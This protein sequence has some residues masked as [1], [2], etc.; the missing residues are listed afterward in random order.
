MISNHCKNK[1]PESKNLNQHP[2]DVNVT[3]S[4]VFAIFNADI[5]AFRS[6]AISCHAINTGRLTEQI[7]LMGTSPINVPKYNLHIIHFIQVIMNKT[8]LLFQ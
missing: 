4:M 2:L 6:T 5:R 8:L 1:N 7:Y 3:R